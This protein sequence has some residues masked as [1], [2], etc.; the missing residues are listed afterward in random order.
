MLKAFFIHV[1]NPH[2]HGAGSQPPPAL[3]S[4]QTEWAIETAMAWI[5][6][7]VRRS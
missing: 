7:L 6:N 2:G 4:H 3:T 5:K 1:R